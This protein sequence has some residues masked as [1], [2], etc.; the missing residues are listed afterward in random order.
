MNAALGINGNFT[1]PSR[2]LAPK[3]TL[4]FIATP[5]SRRGDK[6]VSVPS[7][8]EEAVGVAGTEV[9]AAVAHNS[10]A[11]RRRTDARMEAVGFSLALLFV[12]GLGALAMWATV[13]VVNSLMQAQ[14]LMVQNTFAFQH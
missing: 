12:L 6:P 13:L 2:I 14:S 11:S 9:A 3:L 1:E 7:R 4:R 10:E 8:R 5:A